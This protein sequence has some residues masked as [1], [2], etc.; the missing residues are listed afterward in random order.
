[1]EITP[2]QTRTHT[3]TNAHKQGQ[4][5]KYWVKLIIEKLG[6]KNLNLNENSRRYVNK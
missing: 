3:D 2:K 6:G 1:M 4:N 5:K